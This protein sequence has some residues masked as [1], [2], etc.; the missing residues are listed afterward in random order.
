M[1]TSEDKG[2]VYEFGRFVLDPQEKTLL[3]D[4]VPLRLPA[5]EFETL[6][7]LVENNGRA[8][9][10]DQLMSAVWQDAFVEESNLAKQISRLRKI[11]N[12]RG[13][14][15][16]ETLPKHGYRFTAEVRRIASVPD[17]TNVLEKRTVKRMTLRVEDEIDEP[18]PALPP[19]KRRRTL[20]ELRLGALGLFVL[21]A[22]L[23]VWFW[24]GR[25]SDKTAGKI[26][27]LAVLPLKPLTAEENNKVLGLGLADALITKIG[28][29]RQVAV[30][31]ISAVASFGE[32][33]GDDALGFG[34]KLNVDAVLE[35]TIQQS[36]GR[37]RINARLLE[38]ET[39][40]QIWSE[41]FD[42][43]TAQIFA[44]QDVLSARIAKTLAFE[45]T[46]RDS[47]PLPTHAT[48]N[49]EAY[50]KY[51]RGRFYQ[52]QNTPEGFARSRELYREAIA[53]DP[54][55]ADAHAGL[56]DI[57]VLSF[58]FGWRPA[59]EVIPQAKQS[60]Q[61]A[62]SLNPNL[63]SA[64]ATLALIQFL[65]ERDWSAAEDSLLKSLELNPN[66]ADVFLRYGYFL[67]NIGKFD[68]AI[69]KLE[70]ARQL[71]PLSPIIETDIGLALLCARR[72]QSAIEQLEPV[73]AEN[74]EMILPRAL[75]AAALEG[76]GETDRAF[77]ENL[78]ILGLEGRKDLAERLGKIRE[79]EGMTK[80]FETWLAETLKVDSEGRGPA[81]NL[82]FLYASLKN[83]EKTL[84]ALEKAYEDGE[85]TL[86]QI[87]FSAKYDFIREEERFQRLLEKIEY[88][89]R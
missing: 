81:L 8:L 26:K 78:R 19:G 58:N 41:N 70:R 75:L 5:K 73:V 68:E 28:G 18:P 39:G 23:A 49:V 57:G 62:L 42:Q 85:P 6:L 77:A 32:T 21:T 3:V 88:K 56:A 89:T 40:E 82:A 55:F 48:E 63:A 34:R 12:A 27:S 13:Q 16:I 36:E 14:N 53:L 30:R 11:L 66:N 60:V 37:L 87:K 84:D 54:N 15:L 10:K 24:N 69:E 71:N 45:L 79:T 76:I 22:I 35:G 59:S 52:S 25:S 61:Q 17:G 9:S 4:G 2:F 83:K 64:Y 51:L 29:W 80:A 46:V 74:P 47:D 72:Y 65:S 33:G 43:P 20:G 38:T 1:E 31:P 50:E 86:S 67:I 7:V 44:L